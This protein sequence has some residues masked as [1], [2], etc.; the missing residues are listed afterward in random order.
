[1]LA[2]L[3]TDIE[4]STNLLRDLGVRYRTLLLDHRSLLKTA[5][6]RFGGRLLGSEGD[7]LFAVFPNPKDALLA[8]AEGQLSLNEAKWPDGIALK[9]R[10][11]IHVGDVIVE[12]DEYVG[13]A[14]HQASRISNAAHGNQILLSEA[15]QLA[16]GDAL[17]GDITLEPVG[18]FRLKDF[19]EPQQLFQLHHPRLPSDF[20]APRTTNGPTHNLPRTFTSFIGR[21]RPSSSKPADHAD[22]PW[23]LRKDA[24]GDRGSVGLADSAAGRDLVR[25]FG[26]GFRS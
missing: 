14:I 15:T 16:A 6:E 26:A 10:M 22:R 25:R 21:D 24:A 8:A 19:P 23:R 18:Q 11:G 3:F 20:P 7:S 2:F 9:V 13:L 12:E 4:G 1:M 5:F 17:P